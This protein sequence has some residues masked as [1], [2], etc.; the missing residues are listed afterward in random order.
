VGEKTVTAMYTCKD[1]LTP[2][3]Y[4]GKIIKKK[5]KKKKKKSIQPC[6]E[7]E[8]ILCGLWVNFRVPEGEWLALCLEKQTDEITKSFII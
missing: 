2:L 3:L 4:S 8:V 6:P 5:K 1:D 7:E